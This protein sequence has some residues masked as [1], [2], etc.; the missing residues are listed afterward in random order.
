MCVCAC[1]L[2]G[3]ELSRVVHRRLFR[4]EKVKLSLRMAYE[5]TKGGTLESYSR[6]MNENCKD[7]RQNEG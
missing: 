7:W 3:E 5:I 1:A 2:L 4:G 6:Q